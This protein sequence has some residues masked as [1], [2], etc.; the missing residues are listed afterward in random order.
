MDKYPDI[1][2][3]IK[4]TPAA[5][6]PDDFTPRVMAAVAQAKEGIYTHVWNFLSEPRKFII[7]PARA[8]QADVGNDEVS[9][10]FTV[11]AFAHLT[12]AAVLLMGLKNMIAGILLPPLLRLQPFFFLSMACWLGVWGLL[13]KLNPQ[14]A[15]KGARFGAMV[16]IEAAVIN[17]ILLLMELKTAF[18][19]IAFLTAV[20]GI[21]IV[22]GIFLALSCRDGNFRT[23]KGP[24]V[25][26]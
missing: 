22:V 19:F 25:S 1:I 18:P 20:F 10:Y 4:A 17:G 11:V 7:E 2:N 15:I 8:L 21:S 6:P 23:I 5:A 14:K 12:L 24:P 3:L 13:L 16:Y 9:L 26:A